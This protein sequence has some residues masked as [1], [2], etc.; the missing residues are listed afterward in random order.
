[1]IRAWSPV[2]F[3]DP[4]LGTVFADEANRKAI[5]VYWSNAVIKDTQVALRGA[6]LP[7]HRGCSR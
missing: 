3:R 2:A 6:D 1:V 7:A 5:S 4:H